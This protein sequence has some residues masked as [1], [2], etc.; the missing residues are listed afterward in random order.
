MEYEIVGIVIDKKEINEFDEIVTV[1]S[2]NGVIK[3]FAQSTR[4]L[5]SKNAPSLNMLFLSNFELVNTETNTLLPRLKRAT[6]IKSFP[7]KSNLLTEINDLKYFLSKIEKANCQ[8]LIS[9]YEEIIEDI[10]NSKDKVII[11]IL[12][13]ILLV[14]GLYPIFGQCSECENTNNIVDF[15]FHR[16]GFL[17]RYHSNDKLDY[18]VL[19]SLY[20][21]SK[22]YW[23]FKD[24]CDYLSASLIRKMITFY[25]IENI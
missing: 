8:E 10:E 1:L 17:C 18:N 16:G 21:L 9:T 3:F 23:S 19:N 20:W 24:E 25:L 5:T 7:L 13:K 4:K 12:N 14:M 6:T 15:K 2:N 11:Y 22:T